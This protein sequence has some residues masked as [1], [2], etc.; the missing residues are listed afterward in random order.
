MKVRTE[1]NIGILEN[2]VLTKKINKENVKSKI[3]IY[4]YI[5]RTLDVIIA[6]VSLVF[7]ALPMLIISIAIK[8]DSKGPV[9]FKQERTGKNGKN[10]MLY[11]FRSMTANNDVHNFKEENKLTKVGKF[12]R[13]TSLD[14][15]PQ[16]FNIL[17]NEMSFI[18]PRPWITDYNK[19]FTENQ[20]RRLEVLPGITGLAQATGRNGLTIQEKIDLDIKYV[21]NLS[22]KLDVKVFLGTVKTILSK[23]DA[24]LSKS[25]IKEELE[26]LKTQNKQKEESVI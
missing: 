2:E 9:I 12:I 20:R 5:K 23:Q 18:G 1:N 10:F 21:D 19:Y 26:E 14:E 7:L 11:K 3:E 25:G 24:E 4:P 22:F 15:L 8:I 6:I 13:K 17:K 16:I